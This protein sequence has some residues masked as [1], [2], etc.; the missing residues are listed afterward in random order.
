[1]AP[2]VFA[3]RRRSDA[4]EAVV[5]VTGQHRE[6][7]AQVFPRGA[8]AIVEQHHERLDGSGYPLGLSGADILTEALIVGIADT[9][10]ALTS[11][12]PWRPAV[13]RERALKV[14]DE[15]A[16]VLFPKELVKAFRVA[17]LRSTGS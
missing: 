12:R 3:C 8:G 7:L 11:D 5:C 14:L 16:D 1:M 2:I 4:V 6:M 13:P 9:F 15:A 10:D 17:E